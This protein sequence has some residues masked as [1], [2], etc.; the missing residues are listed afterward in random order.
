MSDVD[1]SDMPLQ[2]RAIVR[3]AEAADYRLSAFVL[4]IVKSR[5]SA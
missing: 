3:Q 2:V 4:G 5:L 1:R